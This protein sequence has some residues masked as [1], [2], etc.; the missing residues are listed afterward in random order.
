MTEKSTDKKDRVTL[1]KLFSRK[2][3]H[4]VVSGLINT[5]GLSGYVQD[6]DGNVLIGN[7]VGDREAFRQ[8][9]KNED[10]VIGYVVGEAKV[11]L[12]ANLIAFLVDREI[13]RRA[14]ADET[15]DKFRKISLLY[16]ISQTIASGVDLEKTGTSILR[17]ARKLITCT[18]GSLMLVNENTGILEIVAAFG[19]N[20]EPKLVIRTNE[21]IAGNVLV[22]GK[23]ELINDVKKD[24]RFITGVN[25]ISSLLC[26]PL[27][28]K[29]KAI[30]VFNMSSDRHVDYTSEDMKILT[31]IASQAAMAIENIIWHKQS[32]IQ[33]YVSPAIIKAMSETKEKI[34]LKPVKEHVAILFADIRNFSSICEELPA[35]DVVNYLNEFF[36]EMVE[37]VFRYGG[38]VNK[39]VGD[40]IVSIFGAPVKYPDNE[41]RAIECAI[42]MQERL[43]NITNAYIKDRFSVGIG[44]SSGAVI[45][46][47]IGSPLHMD[48]TA[49]GDEVNVADRLQSI[50]K[51]GQVLVTRNVYEATAHI[52]EF[53]GHITIYVK[54][55]KK[56]VEV[57]EVI[58][59]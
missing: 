28:T 25:D 22:S 5:I 23:V 1:K 24:N 49:I 27:K 54:G 9:I 56:P 38:V 30:G 52:F 14:L 21:G 3:I 51:G 50:A 7:S 16:E 57:F 43:K 53:K 13:E 10:R 17:I 45:V 20:Y 26:A 33:H 34:P 11:S 47:N 42:K 35:E 6:L 40:M 55:K 18:S 8:E 59:E 2:D 37:I 36:K 48:Y 29:E 12:L 15:L 31:I 44:V 46:G 41:K 32:N 4:Q 19:K 39:F 58:Y